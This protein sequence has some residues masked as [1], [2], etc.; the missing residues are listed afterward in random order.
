MGATYLV[1]SRLTTSFNW[2]KVQLVRFDFRLIDK[3]CD[4]DKEISGAKTILRRYKQLE[5]GYLES[6][7]TTEIPRFEASEVQDK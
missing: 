5:H 4:V 1:D 2:I 6:S 7:L 3:F